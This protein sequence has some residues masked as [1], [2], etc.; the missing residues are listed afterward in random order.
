MDSALVV[1]AVDVVWARARQPRAHFPHT[2]TRASCLSRSRDA[3]NEHVNG[4][5]GLPDVH[6]G[7]PSSSS[8]SSAQRH[9]ATHCR[10]GGG[11]WQRYL[12]RLGWL[13]SDWL[14]TPVLLSICRY[15]DTVC[16]CV[17][18]RLRHCRRPTT[19]VARTAHTCLDGEG[20]APLL[21]S[22]SLPL[23][24]TA[25]LVT[26]YF[27]FFYLAGQIVYTL[28]NGLKVFSASCEFN[29]RRRN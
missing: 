11:A 21:L 29:A 4:N 19:P 25:Y 23:I 27:D 28:I 10:L 18:C 26:K 16:V 14:A 6:F 17:C 1:V 9:L 3:C 15:C 20:V 8:S 12:P 24:A 7:V 22:H 2:C 13:L 5:S